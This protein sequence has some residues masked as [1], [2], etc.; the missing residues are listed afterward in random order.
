M[1]N[2]TNHNT[3]DP[4]LDVRTRALQ[5][6]IIAIPVLLGVLLRK[7]EVFNNKISKSFENIDL[8]TFLGVTIIILVSALSLSWHDYINWSKMH[9]QEKWRLGIYT[10]ATVF[11]F[12]LWLIMLVI[13]GPINLLE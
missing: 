1:R 3:S 8:V 5:N 13:G 10:I 7:S 4:K 9:W 12:I 11:L 6:I 2:N